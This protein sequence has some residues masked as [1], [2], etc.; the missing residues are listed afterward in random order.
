MTFLISFPKVLR[1]TIGLKDLGK[2]YN[3]LL[4]FG[5]TMVI[6]FLKWLGQYLILIYVLAMVTMFFK[7][8]LSLMTRLRCSHDNLSGPEADELLHLTIA[9]VNSSSENNDHEADWYEFSSF[10]MFS[11]S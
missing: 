1:S 10:N 2:L 5:I 6:E 8:I 7:H 3:T 11:S 9:L 4:G